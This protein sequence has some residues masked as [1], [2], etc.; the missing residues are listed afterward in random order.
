M[1]VRPGASASFNFPYIM[2]PGM[3]GKHHFVVTVATN[4]PASRLLTF[5]VYAKS[6]EA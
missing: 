4:D 1:V 5:H 3:G 2:H 6:V